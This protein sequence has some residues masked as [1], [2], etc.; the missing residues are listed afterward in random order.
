MKCVTRI[1]SLIRLSGMRRVAP[2]LLV[3]AAIATACG[4]ET[5][6]TTTTAAL[7]PS[8]TATPASSTTTSQPPTT[9][10]TTVAPTT[11]IV[12]PATT[13]TAAA[14]SSTLAGEPIDFG[15]AEG[16]VL[17]VIG[18]RHDDVLNLRAGPGVGAEIIDR[19]PP[20]FDDLV[21]RGVTRELPSS[22]WI[23]VD[24]EGT[25]GWV[26]I[27]Y[28]GYEGTVTDETSDVIDELG[29]TPVEGRMEDLG[30]MVAEV[31]ASDE[32]ESDI[33]QVTPVSSGDLAEVTFDVV[34]LGD[35]AVRGVRAHVF[36]T[37]GSGGFALRTVEVTLICGRGVDSDSAC[38]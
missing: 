18:V 33:V 9:T 15:P 8:T 1:G 38:V 17:M 34:G 4:G 6:S 19:I 27:S 28:I 30:E 12:A 32:P 24:Y 2:A 5:G 36:A 13:T 7:E 20:T 23:E 31:F 14:G 37:E 3:V 22:F 21:A 29:E 35:D 10:S 11:T 26:N 16:D 25:T